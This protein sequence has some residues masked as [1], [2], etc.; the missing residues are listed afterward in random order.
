MKLFGMTSRLQATLLRQR[1]LITPRFERASGKRQITTSTNQ[2]LPSSGQ[3]A[4][5]SLLHFS[6]RWEKAGSTVKPFPLP[7]L[8]LRPELPLGYRFENRNGYPRG[9]I[10]SRLPFGGNR[11][12]PR[13]RSPRGC[14]FPLFGWSHRRQRQ[15]DRIF[16]KGVGRREL[17]GT[18]NLPTFDAG[19]AQCSADSLQSLG[20]VPALLLPMRRLAPLAHC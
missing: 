16:R 17:G 3:F 9:N 15:L 4:S 10:A 6:S 5:H 20:C 1:R 13:P 14:P 8:Y 12:G 7:C 11:G 2:I 18:R 19:I